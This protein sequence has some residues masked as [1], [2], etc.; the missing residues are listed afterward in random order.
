MTIKSF[1]C[2]S[3]LSFSIDKIYFLNIKIL[4]PDI[5]VVVVITFSLELK[6]EFKYQSTKSKI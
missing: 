4:R 1:A 3:R 2:L 5:M 6:K